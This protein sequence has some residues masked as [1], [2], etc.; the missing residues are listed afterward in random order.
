MTS[1]PQR[2]QIV[3]RNNNER[4]NQ[5][6]QGPRGNHQK[7]Y[8]YRGEEDIHESDPEDQEGIS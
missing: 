7:K 6:H 4:N 5:Q 2:P 3:E 8:L 1:K